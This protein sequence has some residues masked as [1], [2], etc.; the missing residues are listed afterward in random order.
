M[1]SLHQSRGL[2][3]LHLSMS[4]SKSSLTSPETHCNPEP[5]ERYFHHVAPFQIWEDRH[6]SPLLVP[7]SSLLCIWGPCVGCSSIS[8]DLSLK[9]NSS[10]AVLLFPGWPNWVWKPASPV[11]VNKGGFCHLDHSYLAAGVGA[12]EVGRRK[13]GAG[14]GNTHCLLVGSSRTS[15]RRQDLLS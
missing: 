4:H 9:P 1:D 12:F 6:L 5:S 13:A 11:C 14:L 15:C 10:W 3:P 7:Q 2:L 8:P